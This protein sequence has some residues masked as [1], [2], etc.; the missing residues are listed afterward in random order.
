MKSLI[1]PPD[2]AAMNGGN[3]M[4]LMIAVVQKQQTADD[5]SG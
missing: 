3:T 5:V 4:G 1:P 2:E